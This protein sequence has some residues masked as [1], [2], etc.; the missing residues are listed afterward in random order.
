M[1]K[2]RT[3]KQKIKSSQKKNINFGSSYQKKVSKQNVKKAT[4]IDRV[5]MV[6]NFEERTELSKLFG[7]DPALIMR[8]L[9]KTVI[10]TALIIM[11]LLGLYVYN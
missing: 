5:S 9:R 7:Y 2:K 3:K 4:P 10:V 8:D 6:T 11:V 1:A